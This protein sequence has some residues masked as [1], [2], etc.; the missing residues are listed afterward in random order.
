MCTGSVLTRQQVEALRQPCQWLARGPE[1]GDG[2]YP[3]GLAGQPLQMA[4]AA[5]VQLSECVT[6]IFEEL[7][8]IDRVTSFMR[9]LYRQNVTDLCG[10]E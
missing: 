9:T 1:D 6:G 3:E 7:K 5:R 4:K 8:V 10:N 2:L